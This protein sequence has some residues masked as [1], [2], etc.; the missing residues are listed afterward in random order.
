MSLQYRGFAFN[1]FAP[2]MADGSG[3]IG[4]GRAAASPSQNQDFFGQADVPA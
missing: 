1:S 3:F 2:H 4:S